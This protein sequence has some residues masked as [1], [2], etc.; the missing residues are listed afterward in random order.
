MKTAYLMDIGALVIRFINL[1]F[2]KIYK[3]LL[4]K[5]IKLLILRLAN[6]KRVP[7]ITYTA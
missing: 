7:N 1:G 4:I 2:A 3:I 6:N 5:L